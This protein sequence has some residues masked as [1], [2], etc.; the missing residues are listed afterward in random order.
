MGIVNITGDSFPDGGHFLAPADALAHA[1]RLRAE[2]HPEAWIALTN[3][4][5]A[6]WRSAV[7][8]GYGLLGF[9]DRRRAA[10]RVNVAG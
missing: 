1:R 4:R 7:M 6:A 2:G 8:Q 9:G 3:A 5:R 10:H